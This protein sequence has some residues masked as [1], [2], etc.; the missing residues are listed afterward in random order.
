M[1]TISVWRWFGSSMLTTAL[2][3][4]SFGRCS[5][6]R[7]PPPKDSSEGCSISSLWLHLSMWLSAVKHLQ[8]LLLQSWKAG[9]QNEQSEV[10]CFCLFPV[11]RGLHVVYYDTVNMPKM[12]AYEDIICMRPIKLL[13]RSCAHVRTDSW[14]SVRNLIQHLSAHAR[15]RFLL[16]KRIIPVHCPSYHLTWMASV[17]LKMYTKKHILFCNY[18]CVFLFHQNVF[19]AAKCLLSAARTYGLAP[20][21]SVRPVAS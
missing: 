1:T 3:S 4:A 21:L 10:A 9:T 15:L 14:T 16:S 17:L 12:W 8:T 13:Q 2:S 20:L 11:A 5:F 7:R 18:S 6:D 19:K